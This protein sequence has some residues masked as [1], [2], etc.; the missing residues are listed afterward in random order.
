MSA[1]IRYQ[2]S[3]TPKRKGKLRQQSEPTTLEIALAICEQVKGGATAVT[4]LK[5]GTGVNAGQFYL[6]RIIK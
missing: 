1:T 5:E 6:D 4:I 3:W 2:A